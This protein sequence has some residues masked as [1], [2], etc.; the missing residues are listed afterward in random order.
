MPA[1]NIFNLTSFSERIAVPIHVMKNLIGI[2]R[3]IALKILVASWYCDP[4]SKLM[5]V[6]A[7]TYRMAEISA[8][9]ANDIA[10]CL[11]GVENS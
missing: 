6:S 10:P 2:A 11:R 9:A 3:H 5:N 1:A 8:P 4:N 7:Q